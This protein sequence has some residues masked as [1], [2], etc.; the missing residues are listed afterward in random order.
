MATIIY[1]YSRTY[2]KKS[3]FLFY[4]FLKQQ[5]IRN[6]FLTIAVNSMSM[7]GGYLQKVC[8]IGADLLRGLVIRRLLFC[9]YVNETHGVTYSAT[10]CT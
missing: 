4:D 5:S 1:K 8:W 7:S 10:N 6:Y 3:A 9:D 2:R